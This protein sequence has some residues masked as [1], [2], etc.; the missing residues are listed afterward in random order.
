MTSHAFE[1]A[2]F[3]LMDEALRLL[4]HCRDSPVPPLHPPPLS[5]PAESTPLARSEW[6]PT[7]KEKANNSKQ[8]GMGRKL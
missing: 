8:F 3:E 7:T 4:D 1:N 2:L 6:G 5:A